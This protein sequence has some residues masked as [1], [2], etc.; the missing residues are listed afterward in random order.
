M[1]AGDWGRPTPCTE[2]DV[3]GLVNHVTG[4]NVRYRMLLDGADAVEVEASRALD[5]VG[6]DPPALFARTAD[7]VVAAFHEAGALD[8]V[9]DHPAGR[10]TGAELLGQ[11]VVEWAV[12]GWDLARAVGGDEDLDPAVV[13]WLWARTALIERGQRDG[14][15]DA[16]GIETDGPLQTRLLRRFGRRP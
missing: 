2:W 12:H 1:A 4:G 5:H 8:R 13:G 6:E 14:F 11:R 15:Y 16:P 7:E 10:R 3:H 9:V